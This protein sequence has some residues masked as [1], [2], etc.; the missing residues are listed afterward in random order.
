MV[1]E[2]E[3]EP[4]WPFTES[5][6]TR[7]PEIPVTWREPFVDTEP[8]PESDAEVAFCALHESV[9]AP[10]WFTVVGLAEMTQ[11]GV[12]R[13]GVGGLYGGYCGGLYGG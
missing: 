2:H 9:V 10:F 12:G 4:P 8:N 11:V 5:V 6:Y 7:V 1:T 13:G 3:L